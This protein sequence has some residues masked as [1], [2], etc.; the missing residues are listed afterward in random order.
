MYVAVEYALWIIDRMSMIFASTA[1]AA[2][3]GVWEYDF[4][5]HGSCMSERILSGF[6]EERVVS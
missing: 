4:V 6:E 5:K 2:L 1:M 3:K